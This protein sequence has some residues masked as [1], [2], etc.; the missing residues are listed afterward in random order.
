MCPFTGRYV[1]AGIAVCLR[2]CSRILYNARKHDLA[3]CPSA[4]PTAGPLGK[5]RAPTGRIFVKF[6]I[7]VLFE[8]YVKNSSSSYIFQGVGP[9]V[10]PFQSHVSRS[11]FDSFYQSDSSVSLPWVI[12][13]EAFY[14]HVVTSFSCIPVIC[15]K[16]V[17][18]L[19]PLQLVHKNQN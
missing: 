7:W 11:L 9:L 4:C 3:S 6:G 14:L 19:T 8:N 12:Y 5:T 15:P 13:F 10:D 16:L 17:L 1:G 2:D 18:F